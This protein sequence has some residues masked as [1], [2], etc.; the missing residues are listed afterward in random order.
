M[1]VTHRSGANY[2]GFLPKG[3][4]GRYLQVTMADTESPSAVAREF[5]EEWNTQKAGS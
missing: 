5:V 2:L 1:F 3:N 4:K